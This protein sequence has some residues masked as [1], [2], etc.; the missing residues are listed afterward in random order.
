M[1][2]V[3]PPKPDA[4]APSNQDNP[5]EDLEK[6]HP[7]RELTLQGEQITVR[8]YG[9]VEGLRLKPFAKP[10]LDDMEG[11]MSGKALTLP[12][13]LGLIETHHEIIL[14]LIAQSIDRDMDWMRGLSSMEGEVL[15]MT[16]WM[17]NGPFFMRSVQ[18]RRIAEMASEH[19]Q[20]SQRSAGP[21]STAPSSPTDTIQIESADTP[22]AS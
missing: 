11:L 15:M 1:G 5:D 18:N 21:T 8:E 9:F 13:V 22:S 20:R 12:D 4:P 17:V 10:F 19:A 3:L 7:E 14:E 6:L 2:K 16:W